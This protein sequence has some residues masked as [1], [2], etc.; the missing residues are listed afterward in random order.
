MKKACQKIII[1]MNFGEILCK[2]STLPMKAIHSPDPHHTA[3]Q[4][5]GQT[6]VSLNTKLDRDWSKWESA[7]FGLYTG[8]CIQIITLYLS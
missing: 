3:G 8:F 7:I 5:C 4:Y 6:V 2:L 1:K